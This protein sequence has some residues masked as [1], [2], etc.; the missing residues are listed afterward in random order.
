MDD[1]ST[2]AS[3]DEAAAAGARVVP[4]EGRG[5][6]A[7]VNTGARHAGEDTLLV[8]NSDCFLDPSAVHLLVETLEA[9]PGTGVVGAGLVEP[10]GGP[11]RSHGRLLTPLLAARADLGVPAPRLAHGSTGSERVSFLPLACALV[12][13]DAW[14]A[15]GGLDDAFP[16]YFEDHD[17]CLRLKQAGWDLSVRWDARAV[18]V[19]GASSRRKDPQRWLSQFYASRARYLRKH[20]GFVAYVHGALW[21]VVAV[22]RS[23]SWLPRRSPDARRWA[24]AYA[25]AALAG[26]RAQRA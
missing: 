11:S 1:G 2:D 18:H 21:F 7:A 10:D 22:V 8:L 19:G 23:L 16:F 13:R 24:R 9:E 14:S 20:F 26:V 4:S 15:L 3:P 6:S 12:R 17:F 5:F 25:D